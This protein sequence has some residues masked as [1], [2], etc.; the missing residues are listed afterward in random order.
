MDVEKDILPIIHSAGSEIL[1]VYNSRNFNIEVKADK[2]PLTEADQKSHEII[3]KELR[4]KFHDIPIISEEGNTPNLN[5][6]SK[7]KRYFI[8]DPL[9]GT[10]EFLK[11]NGEFTVNIALIENNRPSMGMIHI[12]I[13]KKTYWGEKNKTVMQYDHGEIVKLNDRNQINGKKILVSRSHKNTKHNSIIEKIREDFNVKILEMGSSKKFCSLV[14]DN[15]MVYPRFGP[16]SEWDIAAGHSM[17]E[18]MGGTMKR[19]NGEEILYNTGSDFIIDDFIAGLD[20]GYVEDVI[21]A[22]SCY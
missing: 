11:R 8:V 10:K 9:D 2:S 1:R 5:I 15:S 19:L 18:S 13:E 16:T 22:V 17:I 14:D 3:T 20:K 7:W 12:P 6:R 21:R 4:K